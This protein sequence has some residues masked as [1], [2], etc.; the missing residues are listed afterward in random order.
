MVHIAKPYPVHVD[1]VV[2][3]LIHVPV[4]KQVPVE[5]KVPYPVDRKIPYAVPVKVPYEVERKV[6]FYVPV[7]KKKAHQ[8][9]NYSTLKNSFNFDD[10]DFNFAATNDNNKEFQQFQQQMAQHQQHM[11]HQNQEQHHH[12][13]LQQSQRN[14]EFLTPPPEIDFKRN[15]KATIKKQQRPLKAQQQQQQQKRQQLSNSQVKTSNQQRQTNSNENKQNSAQ[16][17]NTNFQPQNNYQQPQAQA[18]PHSQQ[19]SLYDLHTD[20]TFN[21]P[22]QHQPPPG[23]F[24]ISAQQFPQNRLETD[25]VTEASHLREVYSHPQEDQFSKQH[26]RDKEPLPQP[27]ALISGSNDHQQQYPI[28]YPVQFVQAQPM[29]QF[30]PSFG[31]AQ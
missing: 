21:Q 31:I 13:L 16:Q 10:E 2:E 11:F 3:K 7:E 24:I 15:V 30:E 12:L 20:Y 6:P 25:L 17:Q 18:Q 8:N 5:V 29:M 27:E 1:R 23:S 19:Q 14:E 9:D 22:Q 28:H 4:Y 26:L